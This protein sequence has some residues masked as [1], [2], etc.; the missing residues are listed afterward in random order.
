MEG[1]QDAPMRID[2]SERFALPQA[3]WL[4][5]QGVRKGDA[6]GIYLPMICELP[7]AM[8]ACARIGAMHTVVFAGFS[9]EALSQRLADC[10]CALSR[11]QTP[12]LSVL[13]L[14]P[15]C[16]P[17]Y[18]PASAFAV[19]VTPLLPRCCRPDLMSLPASPAEAWQTACVLIC[20]R[21][22][23]IDLHLCR[24]KVVIT[25]TGV[26]RGPKTMGLK[27]IVDDALKLTEKGGHKVRSMQSNISAWLSD[28]EVLIWSEMTR[29]VHGA[30]GGLSMLCSNCR[31]QVKSCLVFEKTAVPAAATAWTP[32]RWEVYVC[33]W[34]RN[35]AAKAHRWHS[36]R[37]QPFAGCCPSC[38]ACAELQSSSLHAAHRCRDYC[39]SEFPRFPAGTCGGRRRCAS[40]PTSARR[41][42]ST[43]R[44]R[45]SCC[46]RLS[47][48]LSLPHQH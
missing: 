37:G 14:L 38:T 29:D 47:L 24:A 21:R 6:V 41:S 33:R 3:N 23:T 15:S 39:P 46:E 4:K 19:F 42:G 8:L 7:I 11:Q 16:G 35:R 36:M 32:G 18:S 12:W 48:S 25:A 20:C 13:V 22:P 17:E 10:K 31:S 44:T 5:A 1:G 40:N 27:S 43:P 45:C 28:E 30:T 9:A 2:A 26:W 34:T